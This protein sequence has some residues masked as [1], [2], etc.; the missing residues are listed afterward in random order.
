MLVVNGCEAKITKYLFQKMTLSSA[1]F[2]SVIFLNN[3]HY[4]T[5]FSFC[6]KHGHTAPNGPEYGPSFT[7][8]EQVNK[9][10]KPQ[11]LNRSLRYWQHQ[12]PSANE[13]TSAPSYS[14][15]FQRFRLTFETV[16]NLHAEKGETIY[17]FHILTRN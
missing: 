9:E 3:L 6:T 7:N 13:S 16:L 8:I 15:F 17:N 11:G 2:A 4:C 12:I 5:V 14:K 1:I 10:Q